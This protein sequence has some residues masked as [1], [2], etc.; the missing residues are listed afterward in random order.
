[1]KLEWINN[2]FFC[3]NGTYPFY[4]ANLIKWFTI[5]EEEIDAW[6]NKK[7]Y[8]VVA[9]DAKGNEYKL[10]KYESR[11]AANQELKEFLKIRGIAVKDD[12]KILVD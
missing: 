12:E 3:V 2:D 5:R 9:I 6:T 10:C 8:R 1:M 11:T 4:N 7:E